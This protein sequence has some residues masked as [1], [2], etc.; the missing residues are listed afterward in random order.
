MMLPKFRAWHKDKKQMFFVC[1][2]MDKPFPLSIVY[3]YHN[4]KYVIAG[5]KKQKIIQSSAFPEEILLMQSTGAKDFY[6]HE[7]YHSDIIQDE[8]ENEGVLRMIVWDS[9][10]CMFCANLIKGNKYD[11]YYSVRLDNIHM[12]KKGNIFENPE[13]VDQAVWQEK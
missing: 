12:R 1:G 3:L 8:E 7:L 6:N 9:E 4:M 5:E 2:W 13:L 10:Y 11:P